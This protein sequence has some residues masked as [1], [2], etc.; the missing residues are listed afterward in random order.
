MS[1]ILFIDDDTDLLDINFRYFTK[2]GY[3]VKTTTR[4]EEALKLI[5]SFCPDCIILDVM[6]PGINGFELCRRIRQ[7]TAVPIIFLS[8]RTTEN[9]KVKGLKLGGDDYL[10]K[11][12][13]FRELAARIQV[14]L[15]RCRENI[16]YHP[17]LSL[18]LTRH[19]AYYQ[20][21]EIL[22]SNREYDL[23]LLLL[24]Y[25]NQIVSFD[26]IS[27]H[28]WNS[29]TDNDRKTINVIA[30]RLRK[31]LEAYKELAG[32]IETVWSKGY[33]FHIKQGITL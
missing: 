4:P 32:A 13:G 11:P 24:T 15:R 25:A 17:P 21:E 20:E 2:E 7:I 23:L 19:K 5:H 26:T 12:Y 3:C 29:A 33:T 14:Q 1:N 16:I 18:N 10:I 8:G 31:K 28:F 6:M 9:D 27:K 22:L 30:S